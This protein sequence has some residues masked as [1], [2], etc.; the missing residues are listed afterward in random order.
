M[1]DLCQLIRR[2][3]GDRQYHQ[4]LITVLR[5]CPAG[6]GQALRAAGRVSPRLRI[7]VASNRGDHGLVDDRDTL[8]PE[9]QRQVDIIEAEYAD[10]SAVTAEDRLAGRVPCP[11][12]CKG[13]MMHLLAEDN[14]RRHPVDYVAFLDDDLELRVSDLLAGSEEAMARSCSVFQLQLTHDSHAIWDVLKAAAPGVEPE[15]PGDKV[16]WAELPFVEVMGPVIAQRELDR[17]L[18]SVLAPFRSGFGWDAYL[19]PLLGELFPDFRPGVFLGACM[20][21]HRPL[22]TDPHRCFS[23]GLTPPQEEDLLRA[24]MLLTLLQPRAIESRSLFLAE[25][26]RQL[27]GEAPEV[28]QGLGAALHSVTQRYWHCLQLE[29]LGSE[30]S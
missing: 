28:L 1:A 24:A 4:E 7:Y 17:G 12:E 8:D 11:S 13:Q 20:R 9:Q 6:P 15:D 26:Q 16:P 25:L 18:L 30:P 29:T 5:P 27:H 23:N 14:R 2:L 3:V 10:P 21:H 22:R 19:L